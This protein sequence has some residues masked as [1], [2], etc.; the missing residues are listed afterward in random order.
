MH[1]A[2]LMQFYDTI[3]T[4]C[5][6]GFEDDQLQVREQ[7]VLALSFAMSNKL[8]ETINEKQ[9]DSKRK[10]GDPPHNLID[11]FNILQPVFNKDKDSE[12]ECAVLCI[13]KTMQQSIEHAKM[14][15]PLQILQLNLTWLSKLSNYTIE[16]YKSRIQLT[17][18]YI[19]YTKLLDLGAQIKLTEVILSNLDKIIEKKE[20]K[21][22]QANDHQIILILYTLSALILQLGPHIVEHNS[23]LNHITDTINPF[24]VWDKSPVKLAAGECVKALMHRCRPWGCQLLSLFLNMTTVAHAEL[25]GMPIGP[26]YVNI[27]QNAIS[28]KESLVSYYMALNAQASCLSS[29]L[30]C[31]EPL[32]KGV[33]LD[34][35]NSGL[36]SAKRMIMGYRPHE[37]DETATKAKYD[38][39]KELL[40][41]KHAGW[42]VIQGLLGLGNT[43]VNGNMSALIKLWNYTF[44]KELCITNPLLAESKTYNL[45]L[46][47]QDFIVKCESLRALHDFMLNYK[48]LLNPQ[49]LKFVGNALVNC[50]VYMF[51]NNTKEP[52]K[53]LFDMFPAKYEQMKLV[54]LLIC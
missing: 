10:S 31:T 7:Y 15:K 6:K 21:Q 9:T 51:T 13:L 53:Q 26:I 42:L 4:A 29:L 49:V 11:V 19:E 45:E 48:E 35:A 20:K 22:Q 8:Q 40:G 41:K 54:F 27:K 39:P 44:S 38:D 5:C 30:Y 50:T 47:A 3:F 23:A 37:D 34:I 18:L 46:L 32:L 25:C 1:G 24:L 14:S 17:W 12:K 16:A 43:W 33:P 52:R 2:L 28:D 36:S